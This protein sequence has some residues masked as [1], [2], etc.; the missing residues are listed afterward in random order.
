MLFGNMKSILLLMTLTLFSSP[1]FA[2]KAAGECPNWELRIDAKTSLNLGGID[3]KTQEEIYDAIECLLKLKGKKYSSNISG[4]TRGNV[5]QYFVEP[6]SVEVAAL[7]FITYVVYQKWDY[8][9]A[10]YL[11]D[12]KGK[13]NTPKAVAKA[14][15]AYRTWFK[16]VKEIGLVE[17]RKQ[18]LNPLAN[19]TVRWY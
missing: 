6:T 11:V 17:A 9:D 10:P 18:N 13:L 1:C 8:A 12:G 19:S 16:K 4:A 14:Y 2:Q 3:N 15:K 5:S 7:Y